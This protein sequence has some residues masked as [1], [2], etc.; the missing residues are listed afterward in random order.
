MQHDAAD[1]EKDQKITTEFT[2]EGTILQ[3]VDTI[4]NLEETITARGFVC[5]FLFVLLR[6][7]PSQQLWSWRDGQLHNHTFFL[8]KLEQALNQY[9]VHILSL[10]ADN[11]RS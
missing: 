2:L 1:K 6:Y 11:N 7:V 5:L 3:N 8:G 10:L 4:I 9:F